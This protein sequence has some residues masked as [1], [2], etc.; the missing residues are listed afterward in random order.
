MFGISDNVSYPWSAPW[1]HVDVLCD[2]ASWPNMNPVPVHPS[3][4]S[5]LTYRASPQITAG[6]F[7]GVFSKT[8]NTQS[9]ASATRPR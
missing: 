1:D 6:H 9:H 4:Q 5:R 3:L 7:M 2:A 8:L